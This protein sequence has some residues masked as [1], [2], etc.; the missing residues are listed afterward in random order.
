MKGTIW[1]WELPIAHEDVWEVLLFSFLNVQDAKGSG[2]NG[3][4]KWLDRQGHA[5]AELD[6]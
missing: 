2:V 1:A 4:C 6:S 5:S 3:P